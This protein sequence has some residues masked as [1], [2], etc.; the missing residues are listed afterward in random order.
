[1]FDERNEA[2]T[3]S[4]ASVIADAHRGGIRI[5]ICGEAPSN[6]P[7]F[8]AFLIECGIDSMSLNPD[9]FVRTLKSVS[10]VELQSRPETAAVAR[11]PVETAG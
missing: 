1:L 11:A 9:S 5:G 6:D 4:I 8:A 7:A 3:R 2:V 10:A